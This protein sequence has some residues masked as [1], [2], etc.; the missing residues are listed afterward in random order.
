MLIREGRLR[1][2]ARR[3]EIQGRLRKLYGSRTLWSILGIG[4]WLYFAVAAY[5][6]MAGVRR[7]FIY[8]DAVTVLLMGWGIM[9]V[10]YLAGMEK[11]FWHGIWRV[12]SRKGKGVSRME[13]CRAVKAFGC[14]EKTAVASGIVICMTGVMDMLSGLDN[15]PMDESGFL[16]MLTVRISLGILSGCILYPAVFILVLT[17]VKIRLERMVISYMEEPEDGEAERTEADGQR[18]YFGL[19]AMGLT[20]REAEVARLAGVGMSNRE[21]GQQLY[22]AEGTVKKHM[23]HILEKS[24]CGNREAL[25]ERIRGL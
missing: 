11:D 19:R 9:L 12:F 16:L 4:L 24:G 14:A 3:K 23:T 18:Q 5:G 8:Y 10:L 7:L 20:D 21:I 2:V 15:L 6:G 17:P 25:R 1:G 13:L 22:I